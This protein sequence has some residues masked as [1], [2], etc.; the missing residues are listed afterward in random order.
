MNVE[1]AFSRVLIDAIPWPVFVVEEDVRIVDVNTAGQ[2]MLHPG[3]GPVFRQ[4]AGE[5]L[6][7][8]HATDSPEGC[9]RGPFC[10]DCVVR[11]SVNEALDGI[12][13]VRRQAAMQLVAN[14]KTEEIRALVTAAPFAFQE[15]KLAMLILEDISELVALRGL[16]PICAWCK[17]VRDDNDYWQQLE[18]YLRD[19]LEMTFS[20]ALCPDC[21]TRFFPEFGDMTS[22]PASTAFKAEIAAALGS[23]AL[24]KSQLRHAIQTGTYDAVPTPSVAR[25]DDRCR[26]GQFL[27]GPSITATEKASAEYRECR[28]LH[29]KFHVAAALA[30][31]F[32]LAGQKAEAEA[33]VQ[34]DSQLATVSHQL[35]EAMLRWR[36]A[37]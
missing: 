20:H 9:G 12:R 34:E 26:F 22:A 17:R 13:V 33:A 24:W 10:P 6:G 18:I 27:F 8:I 4:R 30:L 21:M 29:A 1:D 19:H 31:E 23:H 35:T 7:C 16:L 15:H 37:R 28:E 32:A 25:L 2:S 11:N 5:A 3:D 14:G 36:R